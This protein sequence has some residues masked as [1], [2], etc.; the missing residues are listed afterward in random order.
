M[1]KLANFQCR[2]T[3]IESNMFP[4][5]EMLKSIYPLPE[6]SRLHVERGPWFL[7]DNRHHDSTSFLEEKRE[8]GTAPIFHSFVEAKYVLE[9]ILYVDVSGLSLGYPLT[10]E[11]PLSQAPQILEFC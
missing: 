2:H 5:T 4:G 9:Y 3:Q 11:P 8:S 7:G 6:P 1:Y 10:L